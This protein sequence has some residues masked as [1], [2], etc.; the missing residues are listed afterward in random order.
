MLIIGLLVV[1]GIAY[2][3]LDKTDASSAFNQLGKL[4][5]QNMI[6][7]NANNIVMKVNNTSVTKS[8]LENQRDMMQMMNPNIPVTDTEVESKIIAFNALYQ[9]SQKRGLE[10]S[11][12]DANEYAKYMKQSLEKAITD[13]VNAPD[14]S[15]LILE[16]IEGTGQSLDQFFE[17]ST[18]GYQKMLSIANLRKSVYDEVAKNLPEQIEPDKKLILQ[19]EAFNNI[20]QMVV[21]SAIVEHLNIE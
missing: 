19:E 4:F 7:E 15:Q 21:K 10:A 2:I 20:E 3:G 8:D 13:P 17:K 11:K 6:D 5:G 18:N 14:N 9:E 1:G 12:E 16:Y